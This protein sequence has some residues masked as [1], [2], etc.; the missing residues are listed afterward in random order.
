V[1]A[2]AVVLIVTGVF[3]LV[4]GKNNKPDTNISAPQNTSRPTNPGNTNQPTTPGN[5]NQPTTPGN[6][7]QPTNP[8]NPGGSHQPSD[9]GGFISNTFGINFDFSP[10][11]DVVASGDYDISDWPSY[12]YPPG[13]PSYPNASVAFSS[14][15]YDMI[16]ICVVDTD[17]AEY[18]SYLS[19]VEANGW[20]CID[21]DAFDEP[22]YIKDS[23]FLWVTYDEEYGVFIFLWDTGDDELA[24]LFIPVNYDWPADIPIPAYTDGRI[25][26][27]DADAEAKSYYIFISDSSKAAY[28]SYIDKLLGAG[29]K[30]DGD[31]WYIL[32]TQD[33]EWYLSVSFDDD[34]DVF[35]GLDFIPQ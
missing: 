28:D 22:F 2:L 13:F 18:G 15:E 26:S 5:T 31:Y 17:R 8:G 24:A 33:G 4:G 23:W 3:G 9:P 35:I 14:D 30:H 32:E 19:L 20:F 1:I 12:N 29:W 16:M 27:V 34:G 10:F 21:D 11:R 25:W 6:T 7:N